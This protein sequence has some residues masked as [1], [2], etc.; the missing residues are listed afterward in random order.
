MSSVVVYLYAQIK[1]SKL[2]K[3]LILPNS[4]LDKVKKQSMIYGEMTT[5]AIAVVQQM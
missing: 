5:P 3:I 2:H 4:T 1:V